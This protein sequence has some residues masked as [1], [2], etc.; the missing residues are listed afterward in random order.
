[1]RLLTPHEVVL[2]ATLESDVGGVDESLRFVVLTLK[3]DGFVVTQ[4]DAVAITPAGHEALRGNRR[5]LRALPGWEQ[6]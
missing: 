4:G 5:R 3:R 6:S 1:M 2:L